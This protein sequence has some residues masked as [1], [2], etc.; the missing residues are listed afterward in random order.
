MILK[1]FILLSLQTKT[2]GMKKIF[3]LIAIAVLT[4]MSYACG[5]SSNSNDVKDDTP[6]VN[7]VSSAAKVEYLNTQNFVDRIFDFRLETEWRYKGKKP[8]II[9]FY[10]DWCGPCKRV[11]PIMQE[12]AEEYKGEINIYKVNTDNEQELA[13]TFG[14]QSI[15]S[16]MFIPMEGKPHMY[17]GAFPKDE[18]VR[19]INEVFYAE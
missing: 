18:Y 13:Q 16:I 5:N 6:P 9:D 3:Y 15:P 17:V 4:L 1:R 8:A 10:T 12:L 11:A 2:Q 14:I 19:I 7:N